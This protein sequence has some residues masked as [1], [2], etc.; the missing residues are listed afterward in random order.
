MSAGKKSVKRTAF[1]IVVLAVGAAVAG[2]SLGPVPVPYENPP[3][4]AKRALGKMLFFEEQLSS[5]NTVACATCHVMQKGGTDPRRSRNPGSNA[6]F[7]DLGDV[8]GSPGVEPMGTDGTFHPVADFGASVQVTP[9]TAPTTFAAIYEKDILWDG[10]AT[11]AFVDPV[12][13]VTVV[14][15]GGALESQALLPLTNPV[16]MGHAGRDFSQVTTKLATVRPLA[17]ASDLPPDLA[18]ALDGDPTYPQLFGRAFGDETITT[19]RIAM[20]IATY[21]RTLVADQTNYDR[22][23]AGDAS[24]LTPQHIR[25]LDALKTSKCTTCHE[26]PL[27]TDGTFRATG[28]RDPKEDKGRAKVTSNNADRGKFKVPTLRNVALKSS[29]FHDGQRTVLA[30]A[31]DFYAVEPGPAV[32]GVRTYGSPS[33]FHDS[34]VPSQQFFDNQDAVMSTIVVSPQNAQDINAFLTEALVDPRISSGAY[35]FD[36]PTLASQRPLLTAIV[37]PDGHS[38]GSDMPQVVVHTPA[39]AGSES[40]TVS[41]TGAQPGMTAQLLSWQ[42]PTRDGRVTVSDPVP[43]AADNG[44]TFASTQVS[45]AG[46]TPDTRMQFAWMLTDPVASATVAVSPTASVVVFAQ[47]PKFV[48]GLPVPETAPSAV[49]DADAYVASAKYGVNFARP[50]DMPPADTFTCVAWLGSAAS[51]ANLSDGRLSLTVGGHDLLA[52]SAM[53]SRGRIA[54][55]DTTASFNATTG[56]LQITLRRIDL[57]TAIVTPYSVPVRIEMAG[58]GLATPVVTTALSFSTSVSRS[59]VVAGRFAFGDSGTG[60]GAFHVTSATAKPVA[61]GRTRLRMDAAVDMPGAIASWTP[62]AVTLDVAGFH[63]PQTTLGLSRDGGSY[64]AGPDG[65]L[66]RLRI[67]VR[68]RTLSLDV[69]A[70]LPALSGAAPGAR[71]QVPVTLT[72]QQSG[73]TIPV[74]FTT[75]ATV[76]VARR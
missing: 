69:T 70:L 64:L 60:N 31:I 11:S 44:V 18:Q 4:E 22:Y 45:L 10:R 7:G 6:I 27:F 30:D 51:G 42:V 28:V 66:R 36:A 59:G 58:L 72:M 71:V 12:S 50:D 37:H 25:G 61:D 43:I 47:R 14:A 62:G 53:D 38:M 3:N 8:M 2:E 67:D 17:L 40:F 48:D 16:E 15:S 41:L 54:A 5:D 13:G 35:P 39:L 49:G 74:T 26:P 23:L 34:P 1:S 63:L 75:T 52:S 32:N 29:F 20:A 55:K 57:R 68:R 19:A 56:R 33:G 21:E 24:A 76:T 73:S 46:A 65:D 9:R